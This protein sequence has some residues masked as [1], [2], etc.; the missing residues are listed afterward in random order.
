MSQ[1]HGQWSVTTRLFLFDEPLSNLD[2]QLRT[3]M[4]VEI[5]KLHNELNATS[6][7]VTHDQTEAMTLADRIVV[8]DGGQI[9]QVGIPE[10]LYE[11]PIT[12]FVAG[13]L[14]APPMNFLSGSS[15]GVNSALTVGVRPEKLRLEHVNDSDVS[16][17]AQLELVEYLGSNVLYHCVVGGTAVA[18]ERT[19]DASTKPK[20]SDNF[21]LYAS[22]ESLLF[23][24]GNKRVMNVLPT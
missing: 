13:F 20:N 2:A 16:F 19:T 17:D 10:E 22:P 14:G 4:R 12:K 5:R 18:V 7:Y 23:F 15:V 11:N 3:Q 6:I 9:E 21:K 1:W 24:D 8:L